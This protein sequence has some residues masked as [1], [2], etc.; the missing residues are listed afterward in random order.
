M[1]HSRDT[2]V[3]SCPMNGGDDEYS[4]T[5]NSMFQKET[6]SAAKEI[7][8]KEIAQ[9]L[10]VKNHLFASSSSSFRIAD[11][12][13]SVGP[14]TF[15]A[16]ENVIEA[17][18]HKYQS[19]GLT[20]Q[21]PEFQVFFNDQDSND[22]NTLFRSLPPKRPYFAAGVPGSFHYQLF[23]T[24]S[25][26]FIHA[27]HALHWLSQVPNEVVD[28]N[29]P[30]WNRGKI[31][32]LSAPEEV[33]KAYAAQFAKDVGMF[34]DAR[35]TELV[36]GGMLVLIIGSFRNEISPSHTLASVLFDLLESTLLDMAKEGL[37][38][39]A[40]VDSFNLPMYL[41]T[42]NEMTEIIEKNGRFKIERAEFFNPESAIKVFCSGQA[43]T[44]HFRAGFEG[45]LSKHFG[46]EI[47]DELFHRHS[48]KTEEFSSRLQS[49]SDEGTQLF[50]A[51]K[52]K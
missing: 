42:P 19:Q 15:I 1:S 10:D 37:I 50:L 38:S 5:K 13:C 18:K 21:I 24:S 11:L 9:K 27:S 12:G 6:I 49:S 32:Y 14:N 31:F 2:M 52:R 35:A 46:S 3:K 29:S 22:F 25:L 47:I 7:I 23:P 51:L 44:M 39:K 30:A 34:L 36:S 17:V 43:C 33:G 4:Y 26:H 20:S 8:D 48:K 40:R 16:M 41:A 45:I 28:E